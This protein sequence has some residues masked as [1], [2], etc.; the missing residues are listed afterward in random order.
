MTVM[1]TESYKFSLI[2]AIIIVHKV[3]KTRV[4]ARSAGT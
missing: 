1:T 3:Q 2:G 4:H